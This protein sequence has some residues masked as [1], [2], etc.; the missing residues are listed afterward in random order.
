MITSTAIQIEQ[1]TV[2]LTI[3]QSVAAVRQLDLSSRE[4][5]LRALG[6]W[7]N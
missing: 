2:L 7:K 3:D 1:A 6:N 5:V 4:Q